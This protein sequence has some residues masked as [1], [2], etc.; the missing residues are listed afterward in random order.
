MEDNTEPRISESS[1]TTNEALS[2]GDAPRVPP[3]R[4]SVY[5]SEFDTDCYEL[6][7]DLVS[8]YFEAVYS[9]RSDIEGFYEEG[10]AEAYDFEPILIATGVEATVLEEL[11]SLVGDSKVKCKVENS[12][13]FITNL[14]NGNAHGAGVAEITRQTAAWAVAGG[15]LVTND[16]TVNFGPG[17]GRAPDLLLSVHPAHLLA[18]QEHHRMSM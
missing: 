11:P 12:Q 18:G 4:P 2:D 16:A 6:H 5:I 9:L 8:R 1:G 13:L 7:G 17:S 14:S 10:T 3:K 15:F